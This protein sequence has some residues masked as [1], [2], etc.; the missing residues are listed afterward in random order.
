MNLWPHTNDL[1]TIGEVATDLRCSK[2]HVANM[3]NGKVR[4]SE[5]LPAIAM[6]QQKEVVRRSTLN[7][8]SA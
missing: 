6:G 8:G 4:G 3:I 1:L 5:P 7:D 2:A